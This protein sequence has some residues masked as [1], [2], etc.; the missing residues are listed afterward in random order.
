MFSLR[1]DTEIL[2]RTVVYLY[3]NQRKIMSGLPGITLIGIVF[4]YD[5]SGDTNVDS[6]SADGLKS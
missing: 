1:E 5:A 6:N 2:E 4:V 3:C